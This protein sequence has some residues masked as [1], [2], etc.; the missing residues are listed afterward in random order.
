MT[1]NRIAENHHTHREDQAT[2]EFQPIGSGL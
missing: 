2:W 1:G